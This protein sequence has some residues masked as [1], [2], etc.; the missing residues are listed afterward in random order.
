M[1]SALAPTGGYGSLL[2]NSYSSSA[3]LALFMIAVLG[4]SDL[5][6]RSQMIALGAFLRNA[7]V[8]RTCLIAM[9]GSPS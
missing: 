5:L 6:F 4:P 9:L 2:H 3:A 8:R 1:L 7:H